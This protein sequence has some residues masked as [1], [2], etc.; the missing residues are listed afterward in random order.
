MLRLLT[1]AP[2]LHRGFASDF[3]KQTSALL[4]DRAKAAFKVEVDAAPALK[5]VN[6]EN[7]PK[8]GVYKH[9]YC[10][11]QHPLMIRREDTFR[12]LCEL[13]GPEQVSPHFQA[14]EEFGRWF[15]YFFIGLIFT[16]S[17]RSHNNHAFG[18]CVMNMMFGMEMWIY[19]LGMYF[20]RCTVLVTPNPWKLLWIKYDMDSMLSNLYELEETQA[21]EKRK[22]PIG[23]ID[24]L[25]LHQE[26][27]GMKAEMIN[28]Y[29]ATQ[30]TKLKQHLYERT[31]A[32]LR[33]TEK[34]EQDNVNHVLRE[35]LQKAIAQIQENATKGD[36]D[37][38]KKAFGSALAGIKK[39]KMMYEGDPLLPVV[40]KYL[41][42]FIQDL[43]GMPESDMSKA[44]GLTADQRTML[45]AQDERNE[46]VFLSQ[47]PPIKHPKVLAHPLF[48]KA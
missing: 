14:V 19:C 15:N 37:T 38:L 32:I 20:A 41:D 46:Q 9:P 11:I 35:L 34:L 17:M 22:S 13:L 16:I 23:Q 5:K 30:R 42:K 6:D 24:Y 40:Q 33:G 27:L 48:Q 3:L 29:V 18:Y 36:P 8:N 1:R 26:Y 4:Q 45:K 2:R 28:S 31:L 12:V 47:A 21:E 44:L 39:G 7:L 25:R 43:E 10:T